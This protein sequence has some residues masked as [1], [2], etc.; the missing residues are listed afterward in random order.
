MNYTTG[1]SINYGK[2]KVGA[3]GRNKN[4][5]GTVN[6]KKTEDSIVSILSQIFT[7]FATIIANTH[8]FKH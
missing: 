1:G 7:T 4:T 8:G 5:N 2:P 6:L 3:I